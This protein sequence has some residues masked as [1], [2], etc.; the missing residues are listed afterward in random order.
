MAPVGHTLGFQSQI[1]LTLGK[2]FRLS[3]L[4]CP[5]LPLSRCSTNLPRL[6][7]CVVL[8]GDPRPRDG[9]GLVQSH[10]AHGQQSW[11]SGPETFLPCHTLLTT[12]VED[13][14]RYLLIKYTCIYWKT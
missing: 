6:S 5:H 8:L 12:W 13:P 10:T 2:S 1:A 4:T 3:E 9:K 14:L 11:V 7:K